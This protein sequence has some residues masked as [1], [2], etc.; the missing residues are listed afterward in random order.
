ME[1]PL[2]QPDW[3]IFRAVQE[4]ILQTNM[5]KQDK[6]RK[7]WQPT[8]TIVYRE[9]ASSAGV[10]SCRGEDFS[11]GEEGRATPVVSMFS[12]RSGGSTLSPSSPIPG[13]P[14]NPTASTHCTVDDVLQL[15][16]QLSAIN[17]TLTSSPS[18]NDKN[19]MPDM[20]SNN[21]LNPDIFLSKKITNKLQQ[22]IQDPLVLASGSL[23]KWCEDFNQTCPFLFPFETR[24]L[25][26][27]CTAFGASRS[28][29]WL[30]SQRDVNLERQRAPGLSPRHADQHEFR[31]G[32]L[33]HERVKVP[34]G[35][36]LLE[37]AQQVSRS[38]LAL[39]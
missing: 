33:K 32:R 1:I 25:Y 19:L 4:L 18:N 38:F 35:E 12:Q 8:Y 11:S 22:Q 24:Q 13:T 36:N 16:G 26:F 14:L 2:S 23:P 17:R 39:S 5:T 9:A 15:L 3:T 31:V 30:Q 20:E 21:N 28:I 27:N 34:R 37:W 29:V 10:G 7:I 6:F